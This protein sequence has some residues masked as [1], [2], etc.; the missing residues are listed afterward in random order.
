[1]RMRHIITLLIL[2]LTFGVQAQDQ[3]AIDSLNQAY[4]KAKH[5]TDKINCLFELGETLIGSDQDTC[6]II[7]KKE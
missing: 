6:L 1:M 7:N 3:R 5:D 2:L 4:S